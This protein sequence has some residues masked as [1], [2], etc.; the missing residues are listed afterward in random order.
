MPKN[1]E[2]VQIR[3]HINDG[4]S[5]KNNLP[6]NAQLKLQY[7]PG[8]NG[9]KDIAGS[10][11]V[12]SEFERQTRSW[13]VITIPLTDTTFLNQ[14]IISRFNVCFKNF[15]AKEVKVYID[16]LYIGRSDNLYFGFED[17]KPLTEKMMSSYVYGY[18]DY[19]DCAK[20]RGIVATA[21]D[22]S[23]TLKLTGNT[24]SYFSLSTYDRLH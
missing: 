19:D 9:T 7:C 6:E 20:W 3:L 10:T 24:S 14:N 5:G 1:A 23:N 4:N 11:Y 15:P 21:A 22:G 18:T 2:Y 16:Y 8:V 17:T 12:L 13:F